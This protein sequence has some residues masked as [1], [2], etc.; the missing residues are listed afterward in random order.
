VTWQL[1]LGEERE[2][3]KGEERRGVTIGQKMFQQ[4]SMAENRL[5]MLP[6]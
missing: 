1:L 2:K 6:I 5:T 3:R 4:V